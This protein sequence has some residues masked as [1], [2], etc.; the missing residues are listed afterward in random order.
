MISMALFL[1]SLV[2]RK[3]VLEQ[4]QKPVPQSFQPFC[5]GS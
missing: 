4:W 3:L 1:S 2:S 5:L